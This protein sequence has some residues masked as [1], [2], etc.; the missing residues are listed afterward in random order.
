MYFLTMK[1]WFF[2][3][4]LSTT[5]FSTDTALLTLDEVLNITEIHLIIKPTSVAIVVLSKSWVPMRVKQ[6]WAIFWLIGVVVSIFVALSDF[7]ILYLKAFL[8]YLEELNKIFGIVRVLHRLLNKSFIGERLW[9]DLLL[10]LLV[11]LKTV[12]V[13]FRLQHLSWNLFFALF[14]LFWLNLLTV[15][16]ST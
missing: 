15:V 5:V 6:R 14:L 4:L 1:S 3:F 9:D 10:R 16:A 11:Y 13:I 8:V 7:N 12:P 2:N